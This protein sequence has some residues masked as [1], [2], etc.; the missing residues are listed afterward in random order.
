[1]A[2]SGESSIFKGA[3]LH[4]MM[5]AFLTEGR[6]GGTSDPRV[7][8]GLLTLVMIALYSIFR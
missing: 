2:I 7:L 8:A 1:M 6:I 4:F 3:E 5:K